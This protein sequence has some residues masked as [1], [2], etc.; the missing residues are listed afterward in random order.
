V[1]KLAIAVMVLAGAAWAGSAAATPMTY[2]ITGEASG[3]LNGV[4]F[5]STDYTITMLGDTSHLSGN[6]LDP[7]TSTS[8]DIDGVGDVTLDATTMLGVT[9][10]GVGFLEPV[11]GIADL[12]DFTLSTAVNLSAPFGPVAGAPFSQQQFNNVA[13]SGGLLTLTHG[14]GSI[15]FSGAVTVASKPGVPEPASWALML[16]GFG[17]LGAVLRHRR[18][19]QTSVATA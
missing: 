3:S 2:T 1:R 13:S 15:E 18:A 9:A 11:G 8:V 12:T 7:L 17:G 16:L 5:S 19:H 6:I 14:S 10:R 4:D